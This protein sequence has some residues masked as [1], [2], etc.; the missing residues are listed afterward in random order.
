[1]KQVATWIGFL[2]GLGGLLLQAYLTLTLRSG[3]GRDLLSIVV[4]FFTFYT[5]LTNIMLVLIYASD[6]SGAGWL[7]PRMMARSATD[8][9]KTSAA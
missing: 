5:I 8:T 3:Q 1:M 4:Y 7:G 6:L 2:L 9:A